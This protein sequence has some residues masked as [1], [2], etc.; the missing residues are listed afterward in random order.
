MKLKKGQLL[1]LTI[2][3]MAFG[4]KGLARVEGIAVFIDKTVPGDIITGRIIKKK[5]N[6]LEARVEK[7]IEPSPCRVKARCE[8]SGFAEAAN[9]RL[10]IT[11]NSSNIKES[12]W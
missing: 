8:Y 9:G 10:L 3:D 6:Y 12:M 2:T 4:G 5:K 1:E 11:K 7:M